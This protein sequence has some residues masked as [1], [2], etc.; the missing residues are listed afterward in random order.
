MGRVDAYAI[1]GTNGKRQADFIVQGRILAA[2][3]PGTHEGHGV[4][5]R[6]KG[7]HDPVVVLVPFQGL[8]CGFRRVALV[9][10]NGPVQRRNDAVHQSRAGPGQG[11]Q[12]FGG[13]GVTGQGREPDARQGRAE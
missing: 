3:Q 12:F 4:L 1:Y 13:Q 8:H 7:L 10:T 6:N 5:G 9:L 2:G 11:F